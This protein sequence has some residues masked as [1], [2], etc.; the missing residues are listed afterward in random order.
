M[1]LSP[2]ILADSFISII[3]TF[4]CV[5]FLAVGCILLV[6]GLAVKIKGLWIAGI[7]ILFV[8]LMLIA[9][10]LMNNRVTAG[11]SPKS[12]SGSSPITAYYS[13]KSR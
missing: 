10:K 3:F 12:L 2:D 7:S 1:D 6:V 11:I 5:L 13:V 9:L 8:L 4:F